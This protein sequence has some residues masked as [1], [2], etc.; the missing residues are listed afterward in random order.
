VNK[1][2]PTNPVRIRRKILFLNIKPVFFGM[3]GSGIF[4]V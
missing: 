3:I 1:T 4:L 2:P